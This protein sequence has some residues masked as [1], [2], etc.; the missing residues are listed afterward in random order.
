MSES[1]NETVNDQEVTRLILEGNACEDAGQMAEA[2]RCYE[3]AIRAQPDS[4]RA[5]L[6]RGNALMAMGDTEAAVNA[7]ERALEKNSKFAAAH[8]NLGNAHRQ[9]GRSASA[10][11]AYRNAIAAQ[12]D[13]ADAELALGGVLEE[14]QQHD[15]ALASYRRALAIAPD[16]FGAH[17]NLGNLLR[18]QGELHEAAASY[19]LAIELAPEFADAYYNLASIQ[20]ELGQPETALTTYARA[21]QVKPGFAE[22]H[23]AAGNVQKSMGRLE[24]A[25]SSFE[26]AGAI[27]RNYVEAFINLGN[28]LQELSRPVEALANYRRAIEINP[29]F[30]EAHNNLGNVYKIMGRLAEAESSYRQALRLKPE[31]SLAHSNLGNALQDQGRLDEAVASYRVAL[32]LDPDF[33]QAY[34]SLLFCLSHDATISPQKLYDEH[35]GFGAQFEVPLQPTW[36]VHRNS[37][38]PERKLILGFVSGD[39]REHPVAYFIEPLLAELA[40]SKALS[41]HA[42]YNHAADDSVSQRLRGHFERW[43]PVAHLSDAALADK[44]T[45]SGI[46]I[47]VDLS[48][49]TGANRLLCFARK[50]APVQVSWI[51]YP[52][53][54]GLRSVDYYL[55]DPHF[56]PPGEFDAQFT[57]KIV[58]LP[59]VAAFVHDKTAPPVN[60]LPALRNGYVTFGSFNRLSKVNA[61]TIATWS[62]LLRALPRARLLLGGM[63]DEAK[64]GA[65]RA[66]FVQQGIE[67]RRLSFHQ[68][69]GMAEYLALHHEVDMCLDTFPY[70]GATTTNHALWMG[71]PTLTIGGA[72]AAGRDGAACMGRLGLFDFVARDSNNFVEMGEHWGK[73]LA[74]LSDLRA[75][76][77]SRLAASPALQTANISAGFEQAL[78]TMWRRWCLGLP[79]ESFMTANAADRIATT[80][81]K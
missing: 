74:A 25:A 72:T 62:R 51:G 33:A 46:D 2:L 26:R 77:R 45:A 70:A 67:T 14:L 58:Q 60:A 79:T 66:A 61:S 50:P 64:I 6:N 32:E 27:N 39:L 75:G 37:R 7:F 30:A 71:V 22:A 48:G 59:A 19:R 63:P 11:A 65:L 18:K 1:R 76:L 16:H 29:G 81:H 8:F 31:F 73:D 57:E 23:L 44:I 54:T 78:R 20:V 28:V 12:A 34:N 17:C 40:R 10:L 35:C 49:H 41:M 56:L 80:Q 68:R 21:L 38:E 43:Y 53:T 24:D 3:A 52:C 13:F 5:H 55:A 9:A 42:F 47:L 36:P 4:A 15:Q 69:C